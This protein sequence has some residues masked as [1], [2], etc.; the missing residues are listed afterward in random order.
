MEMDRTVDA[1][2]TRVELA[3]AIAPDTPLAD[4]LI[5]ELVETHPETLGVLSR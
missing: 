1:L 5:R 2:R 3:A 4:R